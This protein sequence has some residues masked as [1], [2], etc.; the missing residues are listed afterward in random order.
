[1]AEREGFALDFCETFRIGI[2]V[3]FR[4]N[5]RSPFTKQ[6]FRLFCSLR[7]NPSFTTVKIKKKDEPSGSSYFFM[8]E[9]EGFEP[10]CALAQTDF[11]SAP[12]WPLRYLSIWMLFVARAILYHILFQIASPFW[13]DS[14][15]FLQKCWGFDATVCVIVIDKPR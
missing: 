14:A 11:E 7:S 3:M 5:L 4:K 12:L 8:A 1:M 6:P 2:E 10:S 13:K 15:K 9:R